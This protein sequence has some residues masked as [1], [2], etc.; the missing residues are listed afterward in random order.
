MKSAGKT[1]SLICLV[2][3]L[4]SAGG[5]VVTRRMQ[6]AA[7]EAAVQKSQ[8]EASGV[9]AAT[10]KAGL[11]R[12]LELE[13]K[14]AGGIPQLKAALAD[15]VDAVTILD[16]FDSEDWWAPFR[17]RGA[18]LVTAGR[19]LAARMGK[20]DKRM[21]LPD[22][23]T[24]ARA[25]A[26][27]V[28]SGVM[29]GDEALVVAVVPVAARKGE[30]IYLALAMPLEAQDLQKATGGPVMFSDGQRPISV[31][32]SASQQSALSRLVGKEGDGRAQDAE[33]AWTALATSVGPR[34][35]LWVLHPTEPVANAGMMPVLLAI[36]AVLLGALA[37]VLRR[38]GG[39]AG[40]AAAA[41]EPALQVF[42]SPRLQTDAAARERK[43]RGTQPY[44]AAEEMGHR[45]TEMAKTGAEPM[46]SAV[47]TWNA[48]TAGRAAELAAADTFPDRER[49]VTGSS[50]FG[51]YRLLERLGEGGM[52]ELYTAVLHGA[53][54]FRRVFV[55]KRLRPEVA[56]NRAAV[57]QFIDEAKMG[58]TL[59]HSNIVP[60][61]DFGRVG[62]EYFLAL[63]YIH[64][65]DLERLVRRHVEV[66][67]RSL[68]VPVAFY[69]MHE[70]L[71]ALAYAHARTDPEGKNLAIVHRD[72][73][74]GNILVSAR[75]EV[76]L[77]DF[78]IAKA[79]GRMSKTE[80]GMIKGNVS[81][82]S[83]EQARGESVD[84][85]SDLFSA[86][87]VLFY[88]LTAQF[89]YQDET[90]FNRLVRAAI[91]PAQTE[92]NQLGTLP[93][94][95][96]DVLRKALSLDPAKRYQ[97]A[98]EFARDLAGHFTAGRSELA[99][100]MDHLFPELRREGR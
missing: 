18:A 91:G 86:A 80:V 68:S 72:V 89:L 98:R 99:D 100:L 88:C 21:P 63:E 53:E 73:S 33:G 75:G 42:G 85:R 22:D 96:S 82:M 30:P 26:A 32:G 39:G 8:A 25:Q 29:A 47:P 23:A 90:M 41:A 3:A 59:V 66:F 1:A 65:R 56:R 95:A 44:E 78:G 4:A 51:R 94:I 54:G 60:V 74:P 12:G 77:S 37:F 64:G 40:E 5:A 52:A 58:S 34:L 28:A 16:L 97:S 45:P 79:E 81:F 69:I 31:A 2:A 62:E 19:T 83:P 55:V 50:T 87:V 38:R 7:A 11:E 67:G 76:K 61:F 70:A 9:L 93:P 27:G 46:A 49:I 35:S 13:A 15:G 57:E 84:L 24:L 92:F 14:A 6:S 20:G 36:G 48:G 10:Q 71:E 43:R 17:S